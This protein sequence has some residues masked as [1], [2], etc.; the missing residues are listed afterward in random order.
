MRGTTGVRLGPLPF[1]IYTKDLPLSLTDTKAILF[2]D[3]TTLYASSKQLDELYH[4]INNNLDCLC[5]WFR[6]K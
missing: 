6:A 2:A 3:D 5:D 1:I 4:Q